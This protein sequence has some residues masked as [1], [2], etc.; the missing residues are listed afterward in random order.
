METVHIAL[1]S[2]EN[3]I[4]GLTATAGSI[5]YHASKDVKLFIHVLDGGIHDNTFEQFTQKI[6]RLH[7]SVEFSR[8]KVDEALFINFPMWAGNR[9]TYARLMLSKVLPDVK[10]II[11]SDTDYLWL[12]DIAELWAQ[13]QDDVI[14]ISTVDQGG[15]IEKEQVWA[16]SKGLD[17]D[18]TKYF[19]AGLSFYNLEL[20]RKEHII[21]KVDGFLKKYPDVL[22]AD[23]TAMNHLLLGRVKLVDEKWQTLSMCLTPQ[24]V[25]NPVAI[26]YAG[27]IPWTRSKFW[28]WALSDAILLWY[29]MMDEINQVPLGT[30]LRSKLTLWQ[31]FYKRTLANIYKNKFTAVF[32][33]VVLKVTGRSAYIRNITYYCRNLGLSNKKAVKWALNK[34]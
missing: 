16:K 30:T 31:R 18:S 15:T 21:E 24:N 23:Q 25:G 6:Y 28:T 29:A 32:F 20:F 7:P 14:F 2:D 33:N 5:A 1:P 11:Y 26:H 10:H 13:R 3:Y 17:F 19:C 4:I 12:A 27:D 8:I 34:N 9:M 22:F